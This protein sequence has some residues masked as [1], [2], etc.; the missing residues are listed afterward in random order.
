MQRPS[1]HVTETKSRLIFSKLIPPE[2]INRDIILDYGIDKSVEIVENGKVTGKEFLAQIKGTE[3]INIADD[4]VN[5][6]IE[7]NNLKYYLQRDAPVVIVVVDVNTE[8]GYWLFIQQYIY[9]VL[10]ESNP[11]WTSQ[12]T[13]TIKIPVK[14]DLST[15][16]PQLKEVALAGSTYIIAKRLDKI[17]LEYLG[18]WKDNTEAISKLM[19]MDK[20]LADKQFQI[21]FDVAYRLQKENDYTKSFELLLKTA[22]QAKSQGD[23][24][25][26][27]KAILVAV[28]Q[29]NPLADSKQIVELLESIG[30][31]VQKSGD[32]SFE[33]MW[34][35]EYLETIFATAMRNLT[36]TRMMHLVASQTQGSSMTPFL[37]VRIGEIILDLY[38]VES[39]FISLL[40]KAYKNEQFLIYLDLL[41]RLAKMQFLWCYNNALDVNPAVTYVQISSIERTLVLAEQLSAFLSQDYRIEINLDLAILYNSI[42]QN[43]NRDKHLT[44][45]MELAKRLE[46]KGFQRQYNQNKKCSKQHMTIPTMIKTKNAPKQIEEIS[47]EEEEQIVKKLLEHGGIDLNSEDELS[48][49]CQ[50]RYQR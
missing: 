27:I 15:T 14:N 26:R 7:V 8:K 36:S 42:E 49:T 34:R 46:H 16:L 47:D 4:C 22:E 11:N 38:K 5:Y 12:G 37:G 33:L 23:A 29:L 21:K 9:E 50:N 41:R 10:D 17:P 35:S 40:D 30:E 19:Q 48:P 39:E 18:H 43:E 28:Y 25:S 44:I 45:A 2:W 24:P 31:P 32:L 20:K 3:A 13:V 6:P 1:Q